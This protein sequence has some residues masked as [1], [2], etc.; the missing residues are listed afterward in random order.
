MVEGLV[1]RTAARYFQ[2]DA[3]D[4]PRLLSGIS[5]LKEK[6]SNLGFVLLRAVVAL[7]GRTTIS[8]PYSAPP[9]TTC[10]SSPWV[11]TPINAPSPR[12]DTVWLL[13]TAGTSWLF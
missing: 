6:L 13:L 4:L 5:L 10:V 8:S 1:N 2:V 9:P 7:Q 3:A 11:T 12:S